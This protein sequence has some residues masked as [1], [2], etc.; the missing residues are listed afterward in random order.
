LTIH[1]YLNQAGLGG[2][3]TTWYLQQAMID[4]GWTVAMSGSGGGGSFSAVG[5]VFDRPGANP[6]RGTTCVN[7][8]DWGWDS[9]WIV[10]EDPGG[11]RQL[12][13]QRDNAF[14]DATDSDWW[15]QWNHAADYA[16]GGAAVPPASAG[17][18]GADLH[19]ATGAWATIHQVG[20]L[21]NMV[22]VAADDT[23]SPAG[24]YGFICMEVISINA[25][26]SVVMGD[27][28]RS[29]PSGGLFAPHA[30]GLYVQT[31]INQLALAALYT[32]AT[33]PETWIDL[34][35]GGE[36]FDQVAY[37]GY[38]DSA[39]TLYP[40][41]AGAPSSGE[42]PVP[43][44]CGNRT[45]GGFGGLS[46]WLRWASTARGYPHWSTAKDLWY[47]EDVV[48]QGLPDGILDPTAMP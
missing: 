15:Y 14:G 36:L 42:V 44:I 21:P 31:G 29:V 12:L 45:H 5:D 35:G 9:C 40:G 7:P 39:G 8:G 38:V 43:I 25:V 41:G 17:A 10:L 2:N 4:A 1:R 16:G 34:G 23:A 22:H 18:V 26:R 13:I 32:F 28:L 37:H 6:R 27:D 20:N 48:I 30:I 47:F 33:A 19:A 11:N 46:R 3:Y 24:E